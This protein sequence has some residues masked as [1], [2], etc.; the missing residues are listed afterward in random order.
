MPGYP[1]PGTG[2]RVQPPDAE[3]VV[4]GEPLDQRVDHRRVGRPDPETDTGDVGGREAGPGVGPGA[5]IGGGQHPAAPL[6]RVEGRRRARARRHDAGEEGRPLAHPVEPFVAVG[7]APVQSVGGRRHHAL[8]VSGVHR[9]R[10]EG[11][12]VERRGAGHGLGDPAPAAVVAADRSH[13]EIGSRPG[14]HPA[15]GDEH[16]VALAGSHVDAVRVVLVDGDGPA[17]EGIGGHGGGVEIEGVHRGAPGD[18]TVVGS[19]DPAIRAGRIDPGAV[20]RDRQPA[21][22][23]GHGGGPRPLAATD[24]RGADRDPVAGGGRGRRQR[25]VV[26][27]RG[28]L[29]LASL[30]RPFPGPLGALAPAIL[31]DNLSPEV[32]GQRTSRGLRLPVQCPRR[33]PLDPRRRLRLLG[34]LV[35]PSEL[36]EALLHE[37][38]EPIARTTFGL[39]LLLLRLLWHGTSPR[40]PAGCSSLSNPTDMSTRG[41]ARQREGPRIAGPFVREAVRQRG[42]RV[43][44]PRAG[45]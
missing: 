32:G 21:D 8:R 24:H 30:R 33:E 15:G 28:T 6:R 3:D 45:P 29:R 22:P 37:L 17:G 25:R 31:L 10:V 7:L 16:R 42:C 9:Q 14:H 5:P 19:P 40:M 4:V 23:A 27:S 43:T 1:P 20:T 34:L 38:L 39:S 35:S 36:C 44:W 13:A 2:G 12:P 18:P 26:V 41:P 11:C